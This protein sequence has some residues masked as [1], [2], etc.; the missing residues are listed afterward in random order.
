MSIIII[1]FVCILILTLVPMSLAQAWEPSKKD[2]CDPNENVSPVIFEL[3]EDLK[4]NPGQTNEHIYLTEPSILF[5]DETFTLMFNINKQNSHAEHCKHNVF[6]TDEI[7]NQRAISC[8]LGDRFTIL[9][10]E[11]DG[12]L[13]DDGTHGDLFSRD[14]I[15][16]RGCIS[17][18]DNPYQDDIEKNVERING[19]VF[20]DEK[21]RNTENI[22]ELGVSSD[23]SK[24][25]SI[26][27]TGFFI[28]LGNDYTYNRKGG[29]YK[30]LY[31]TDDNDAL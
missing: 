1:R 17:L 25:I 13:F 6:S 15:Y 19:M 27:D 8:L 23:G 3:L 22:K 5:K 2:D 4:K 30:D 7:D 26:N 29:G 14:G 21:F 11:F 10:D 28:S 24:S 31:G 9:D 16:S 12:Y 18:K 20:I